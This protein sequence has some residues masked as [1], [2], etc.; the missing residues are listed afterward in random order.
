MR[1]VHYKSVAV[2]LVIHATPVK[3]DEIQHPVDFHASFY[4]ANLGFVCLRR[5]AVTRHSAGPSDAV[6]RRFG[7]ETGASTGVR[8]RLG[9]ST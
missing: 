4:A 8:S 7:R 1:I 6:R 2:K 5:M 9:D 3:S